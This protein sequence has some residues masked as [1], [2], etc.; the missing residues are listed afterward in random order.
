MGE[1]ILTLGNI[2]IEKKILR[3]Y[4]SYFLRDGDIE[5]I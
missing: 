5:I 4:T 2:E 1:E 3:S